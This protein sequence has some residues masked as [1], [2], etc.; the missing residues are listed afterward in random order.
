MMKKLTSTMDP[1]DSDKLHEL[2]Q[3]FQD[4]QRELAKTEAT[5]AE[6][7][8]YIREK[9]DQLLKVMGTLPLEP[10]ELDDETLISVDPIG[11]VTE[12]FKQVL[13]HLQETNLSLSLAKEEIQAIFDSAGAGIVVVDKNMRLLAYN[14]KSQELFMEGISDPLGKNFRPI[15][16][17]PEELPESCIFDQVMAT[18]LVVEQADFVAKQR[19]Y[20]V[21]GTP[22]KDRFGNISNVI[23]VY[24]DV[25]E[26]K[27]HEQELLEAEKRLETIVNSAQ[28]GIMLID[29]ETHQIVFTNQAT[30][31]L[32]GAS[33]EQLYG[34]GCQKFICMADDGNCPIT[35]HHQELDNSERV[36]LTVD[37]REVP[38][39]K[40]VNKV[41]I[42]DKEL[43]LES[44]IDITERKAAEEK[45]R[46]SEKRFR[47]LFS[48]MQEGVAQH[49]M[50]YT[51]DGTPY[52]YQ[53]IDINPSFERIFSFSRK[54]V[55]NRRGSII[56]PQVDDQPAFLNI[57]SE[58]LKSG[59]PCNFEYEF[60]DL[61]MTFQISA[62]P[63]GTDQFSAVFEDITER[64]QNEEKI[65]KL[66]YFDSLTGLPNRI[67][68]RDRLSQMVARARRHNDQIGLFFLDLD[69]FKRINDTLGHDTGDQL[70]K[71]VAERLGSVLR[72]CDTI[73]RLGGD[74]FVILI[75]DI[76]NRDG[77]ATLACKIL[78]S[79]T[80]Q[81]ILKGK[82]IFTSTSIGIA[83]YPDD[84]DDPDTLLKNADTAMY[85]AKDEGRNTYFF[86][87]SEMN[88]E[89]LEQLLLAN[90]LRKALERK[91]FYL[92]YQPQLDLE[93]GQMTGVEALLRWQHT[94]LGIIPPAQFIP[95]AEET[96]LI[97]SIGHWVMQSAC[98]QTAEI[99][100]QHG[101]PLRVAVNL[102]A[103]QFRDPNLVSAV[104]EALDRAG[105]AATYLELEITESILMDNIENAQRILHDLKSMGIKIAIDDFGTGYSS[106]S[107]LRHFPIDRLKVDKTFI[108]RITNHQDDASITEAIIVMAHILGNRVVAEGVEQ[109]AELDFLR[110]KQCDEVQGFYFC[111]PLKPEQ[112]TE[113]ISSVEPSNPFCF[114]SG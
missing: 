22:I 73:S 26:R 58:M 56:Y 33:Q 41:K 47:T 66:A 112:L 68:M 107:Y 39:L 64:K 76:K 40:T 36:L 13:D 29:P 7:R 61:D 44:F 49:R 87:S 86:Y 11:I 25:T 31:Q 52:D 78:E 105:L 19:H 17:G 32:T 28:A 15:I 99:H 110:E 108:Q 27:K 24:T 4:L 14:R 45:L 46:E 74:E 101:L 104:Q 97:L 50:L 71:V 3:N 30:Q 96:G 48:T 80:K 18:E 114:F 10:E 1:T 90:D 60:T 111:H 62:A 35:D 113:W 88:S 37:G 54:Q 81:I 103:K 72:N 95:L 91:E 98:A 23:L 70:L 20:H 69:H 79:L 65:E 53:I 5:D 84:G 67:L 93:H 12:S 94:D 109:K 34:A 63:L 8:R 38:I 59:E 77:A 92:V 6:L 82:E 83:L 21:I 100:R 102:S 89:A 55:L 2:Q 16:C 42:A 75:E 57:F 106:L 85:R 51:A 9:T 43:L